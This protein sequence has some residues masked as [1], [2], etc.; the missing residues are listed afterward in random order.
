[1]GLFNIKKNLCY[2]KEGIK[3]L[4]KKKVEIKF[5]RE[6]LMINIKNLNQS[7]DIKRKRI[8]NY[9]GFIQKMEKCLIRMYMNYLTIIFLIKREVR[10]LNYSCKQQ[11]WVI[12]NILCIERSM[13]I[14]RKSF[15]RND[16]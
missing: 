16:I 5:E 11:N 3:L 10:L 15:M 14:F 9:F 12:S 7:N 6:R 2:C 8:K 13:K 1:M 4:L